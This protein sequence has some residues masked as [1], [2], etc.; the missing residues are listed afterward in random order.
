MGDPDGSSI[1]KYLGT[2][3]K[4]EELEKALSQEV[5]RSI[6]VMKQSNSCGAKGPGQDRPLKGNVRSQ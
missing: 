4:N 3:V 2:S 6:V 5:R 1:K